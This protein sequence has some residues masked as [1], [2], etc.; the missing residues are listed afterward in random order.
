MGVLE[1]PKGKEG[2]SHLNRWARVLV[3]RK[4]LPT[5]TLSGFGARTKWP[6]MALVYEELRSN[7]GHYGLFQ[8]TVL[9]RNHSLT[10]PPCP[11][12]LALDS[13]I[14]LEG[15]CSASDYDPERDKSILTVL[16]SLHVSPLCQGALLREM[17]MEPSQVK[18]ILSRAHGPPSMPGDRIQMSGDASL[19][20]QMPP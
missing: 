3:L 1:L 18:A 13:L 8:G 17:S 15:T 4:C 14:S 19:S 16:S 5:R 2:Q 11:G 12:S 7:C 6:S 9:L 10:C 20:P